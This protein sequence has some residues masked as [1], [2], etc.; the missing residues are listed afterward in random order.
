MQTNKRAI[1]QELAELLKEELEQILTMEIS[2]LEEELANEDDY[3]QEVITDQIN[4]LTQ[5]AKE[6]DLTSWTRLY[7]DASAQQGYIIDLDDHDYIA[8]IRSKGNQLT[9]SIYSE[10][11]SDTIYTH[12]IRGQ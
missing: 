4:E 6:L 5:A 8:M 3:D 10:R 9:A 7:E 11:Y 1:R 12:T 2:D